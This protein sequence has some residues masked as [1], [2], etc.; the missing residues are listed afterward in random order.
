M[1]VAING[2]GRIGRFF[3]RAAYKDLEIIAI[4]DLGDINTMAHLLK[5]DSV[6]G[7]FPGNVEVRDDKLIVDGR[8][9]L[10]Y[11]ERDPEN[12][13]WESL[14]IDIVLEST[15]F[16]RTKE[17]ASKH[18]KA[19]A[20]KVV[21]SAPAKGGDVKT[22]VLGVNEHTYDKETDHIVSNASC[23]TNCLAPVVKVLNDNYGVKKGFMSTVHAYTADQRLVDAPHPDLRRAR[24][25]AINLVPT[26]TGAA[27]ALGLVIPEIDGKLD[28]IAIRAPVS[29]GSVVYL[30][31]E[32]QRDVSLEEVKELFRNVSQHHLKGILE[33]SE[34][35]LVSTDIVGNNHSS[36]FDAAM[37]KVKS[38]MV[39]I[40]S[41][42]D[43]EWGYSNRLVDLMKILL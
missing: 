10:M 19:G 41:W 39:Q 26:T 34:Q 16:F 35:P 36:I 8:E 29:D 40:M 18:L 22:I 37:L 14:G 24:A 23:T 32:L 9:I 4:N 5:H 33:Y 25:A 6:H 42:Y 21:I 31:A 7:K 12:L 17:L 1:K 20:K 43:N 3:F 38:N 2:F 15:G 11:K 28:G 13:P 27:S 30:V